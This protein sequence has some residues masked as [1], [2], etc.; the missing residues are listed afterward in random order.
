MDS[1][2]IE[3]IIEKTMFRALQSRYHR[4]FADHPDA[5]ALLI[6]RKLSDISRFLTEKGQ[7]GVYSEGDIDYK[8]DFFLYLD[9]FSMEDPQGKKFKFPFFVAIECDEHDYHEKT[10]D[11][12]KKD[13]AK[14]NKLIT[15]SLN[16]LRFTAS[17]IT[18]DTDKCIEEIDRL[19]NAH[20]EKF[21]EILRKLNYYVQLR[22]YLNHEFDGLE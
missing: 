2:D 21:K 10:K 15:G 17:E 12:T 3:K 13:K 4:Y 20:Y 8:M 9:C 11:R 22:S 16:I 1:K 5:T 6:D 19:L 18:S 7:K 14:D